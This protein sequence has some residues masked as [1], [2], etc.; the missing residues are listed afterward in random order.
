MPISKAELIIEVKRQLQ[1]RRSDSAIPARE[2]DIEGL[3]KDA[4]EILC[5]RAVGDARLRRELTA[6]FTVPLD[7]DLEADLST[8]VPTLYE[9][10]LDI[11]ARIVVEDYSEPA[12]YFED[13]R[14]FRNGTPRRDIPRVHISRGTLMVRVGGDSSPTSVEIEGAIF[15]PTIADAGASTTLPVTL[16]SDFIDIIVNEQLKRSVGT[17]MI[18]QRQNAPA[19]EG[20]I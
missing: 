5:E 6:D 3:I 10:G 18:R 12:D 13:V 20:P 7:G 8:E 17:Q 16:E 19:A 9:E 11:A 2:D 1:T 4:V 15:R 14:D